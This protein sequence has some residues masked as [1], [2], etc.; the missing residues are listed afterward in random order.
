MLA[1]TPPDLLGAWER[2]LD[3]GPVE[4]GLTL[5]ALACPDQPRNTLPALSIGERDR[6]LL[7][8]R[9]ALFGS[10]LSGLVACPR[11]GEQLELDVGVAELSAPPSVD[12]GALR[13]QWHEYDVQVR[14]PDSTDLL[15]CAAAPSDDGANILLQRCILATDAHGA[16]VAVEQLPASLIER[17]GAL[18]AA[19]D[20]QA[21]MRFALS[22]AACHFQWSALFDVVSFLWAELEAWAARMLQEV[23]TLAGFYGWSEQAILSL[24]SVRRQAYLRMLGA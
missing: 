12:D 2:G 22:C 24:S 8:L 4:R 15:A 14:L 5:L 17:S 16:R 13:L 19:A 10:R 21:D 6:R 11:C 18:L 23:H 7:T 1:P 3:Q 9:G 20:P